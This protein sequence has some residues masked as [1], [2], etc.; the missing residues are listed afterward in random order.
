MHTDTAPP[1]SH[2]HPALHIVVPAADSAGGPSAAAAPPCDEE[3]SDGGEAMEGADSSG[4]P[5]P[6]ARTRNKRR[7]VEDISPHEIWRCPF[8]PCPKIYKRTS[9]ISIQNHRIACAHRP[10]PPQILLQFAPNATM[11]AGNNSGVGMGLGGVGGGLMRPFGTMAMAAAPPLQP[12]SVHAVAHNDVHFI[13]QQVIRM[14]QQQ[15]QQQQ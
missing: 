12:L 1:A 5:A 10:V 8:P 13:Q 7:R 6:K 4:P 15:Q 3:E 14:Q 2:A 9:T 11:T